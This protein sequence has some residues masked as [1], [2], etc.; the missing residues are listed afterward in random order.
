VNFYNLRLPLQSHGHAKER[1]ID[2]RP[3]IG[4][5]E[6]RS[7]GGSTFLKRSGPIKQR[8]KALR[9]HQDEGLQDSE[10]NGIGHWP[11]VNDTS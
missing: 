6:P 11:E 5:R 10:V 8:E 7:V 9:H 3:P 1:R 4:S 2:P